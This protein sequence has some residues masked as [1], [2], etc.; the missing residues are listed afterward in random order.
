LRDNQAKE[1]TMK[2]FAILFAAALLVMAQSPTPVQPTPKRPYDPNAVVR[3]QAPP[4][5]APTGWQRFNGARRCEQIDRTVTCDN[6]YKAR[7]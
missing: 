7:L 4:R 1:S 3:N 6:G 2:R 5:A